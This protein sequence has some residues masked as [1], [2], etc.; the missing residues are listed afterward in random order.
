M[1]SLKKGIELG[2][3]IRSVEKYANKNNL[4]SNFVTNFMENYNNLEKQEL[5]NNSTNTSL[6]SENNP[7]SYLYYDGTKYFNYEKGINLGY[8][9]TK[10]ECAKCKD[11]TDG[12]GTWT[13][14]KEGGLC[15]CKKC[16]FPNSDYISIEQT[17]NIGNVLKSKNG[18]FKAMITLNGNLEIHNS[19]GIRLWSTNNDKTGN[20][21]VK[22]FGMLDN[23]GVFNIFDSNK[24]KI[25]GSNS[26]KG[27]GKYF[28][29]I[30]NDGNFVIYKGI[31]PSKGLKSSNA[32]WSTFDNPSG[33]VINKDLSLCPEDMPYP[34]EYNKKNWYCFSEKDQKGFSCSYKG[35]KPVP[36]GTKKWG[37]DKD[38][39]IKVS[40][41][42]NNIQN[43]NN[44]LKESNNMVKNELESQQ[45]LKNRYNLIE[46]EIKIQE[47][48]NKRLMNELGDKKNIILTRDKMLQISQDKNI[49]KMKLIYGYI[50]MILV[51]IILILLSYYLL[52]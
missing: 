25:W 29:I 18:N 43:L 31:N 30:Q 2:S 35:N 50:S 52:K 13:D 39:C 51:I 9:A 28:A 3:I 6:C 37:E 11:E 27:L 46:K 19:N 22:Y 23:T 10:E 33:N 41:V 42:N 34:I 15:V 45:I 36:Y 1:E 12:N 32:I 24:N 17:L 40:K 21:K 49:Y 8:K 4:K 26:N 48:R 20:T 47:N 5:F 7:E 14:N 38:E 16:K 44:D